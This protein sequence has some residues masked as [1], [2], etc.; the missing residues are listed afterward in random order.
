MTIGSHKV[1]PQILRGQV[2]SEADSETTVES[3]ELEATAAH[4]N[5]CAL[6]LLARNAADTLARATLSR[7]DLGV[8]IMD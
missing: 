5:T 6:E 4:C 7:L 3:L 8:N 1:I 2:I